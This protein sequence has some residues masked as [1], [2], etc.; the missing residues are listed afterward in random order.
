MMKRAVLLT[1]VL[2]SNSLVDAQ[3]AEKMLAEQV[4]RRSNA[5][6]TRMT[7]GVTISTIE[8]VQ[9]K[10]DEAE[11]NQSTGEIL[12]RGPVILRQ[13]LRPA[14]QAV[15][16]TNLAGEPFPAPKE[17]VMRIRGALQI[18]IGELMVR[19]DEADVNGLTGEMA[20]RGNVTI[21]RPIWKTSPFQL[22]A[23]P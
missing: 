19:A 20:L 15:P 7:G 5:D 17:V 16:A 13:E 18:A 23:Q 22:P 21:S 1:L 14:N 12:L 2:G 11:Y 4:E 3:V 9:L 6:I 8:N 10:A